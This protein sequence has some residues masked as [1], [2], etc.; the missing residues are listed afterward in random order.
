MIGR[1]VSHYKILEK[2]GEGGMG[3]VYKAEDTRLKRPVALKFLPQALTA[4]L[5]AKERFT[6]EAQAASALDH[7][8]ICNIYEINESDDGQLFMAMAC[9]D[10]ET[11][12]KKIERGP[13]PLD[14]A[15]GIAAQVAQGLAKAQEAGIVHRDIKPANIIV[16]KDGIAKIVD[17]GLA[18]LSGRTL[19]TKTGTTMGTAAYMSPE[20]A[21]SG[22]VDARTDI[23][24]LGVVLYEMLTSKRP[25]ESDYE[26]A[27]VYSIL[28]DEPTAIRDVRPEI[29]GALEKI[30]LRAMAKSPADRYP[31]LKGLI[32]DLDAFRDS[33]QIPKQAQKLTGRK[34]K[35]VYLVAGLVSVLVALVGII[36]YTGRAKAIDSIAVLPFVNESQN[37]DIE[38]LCDGLTEALLEDLCRAPGIKKVTARYSVMEYKNKTVVPSEASQK[39]GVAAILVSRLNQR[40]NDVRVAVELI[41]ASDGRRLWG[42]Q[43]TTPTSGITGLHSD[44]SKSVIENLHLKIPGELPARE[45][46]QYTQNQDAYRLY[47]QGQVHYHRSTPEEIRKG[48]EYYRKAIELDPKFALAYSGIAV[49]YAQFGIMGFAPWKE[50]EDSLRQALALAMAIDTNLAENHYVMALSHYKNLNPRASEEEFKRCLELNPLSADAIHYYGHL[51][52]E[53]GRFEEGIKLMRQSVDLDPLSAHYQFCLGDVYAVARRW[54]DALHEIDR[55]KEMDSTFALLDYEYFNIYFN[56]GKYDRALEHARRYASRDMNF[57]LFAEYAIAKVNAA[58][59]HRDD[60]RRQIRLWETRAEGE[61]PDPGAVAELYSLLGEKDSAM[62]WLERAYVQ[63]SVWLPYLK[64]Y[65]GFDP[66]R[67][68]PRFKELARK[69]GFAE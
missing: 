64:V 51:T 33:S 19:L 5:E 10:G 32:V 3:V 25:F 7:P 60:V 65:P 45:T 8:N 18:K 43:Y 14:E 13:L 20:Q 15:V 63:H 40:G 53:H 37:P 46:R 35:L 12:K 68:D 55:A 30:V 42:M 1:V 58:T 29:P 16:T 22:A 24:S 41:A 61:P 49:A 39:L 34:R 28:H 2:L 38:Y 67:D 57:G 59:G 48:I 17:F 54:D 4:D 56:T 26:Q 11:L 66:M 47:L 21:R 62:V 50:A 31:D 27:L 6:H 9:Y 36:E 23:W 52:A 69:A 44:I